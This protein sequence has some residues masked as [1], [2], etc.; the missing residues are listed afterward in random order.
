MVRRR[1]VAGLLGCV[2]CIG[3][4]LLQAQTPAETEK[5]VLDVVQRFTDA[6]T[7]FN[8]SVLKD[9]TAEE[10]VEVSP[11]GDVDPRD[12]ML[13]F[14]APENK[15]SGV[16]VTL[17]EPSV[18][19]FSDDTAIVIEKIGYAIKGPDGASH[20]NDMRGTFVLRKFG[21]AWKLI[22]TQYTGY[23]PAKAKPANG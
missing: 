17:S 14:Y 4:S 11:V 8:V 7:A 9:L 21:S 16:S 18:R 13:G 2:M 12:K 6:Q 1:I 20:S 19:I 5:K 22:S 10:Y 15:I 23:R 3:S